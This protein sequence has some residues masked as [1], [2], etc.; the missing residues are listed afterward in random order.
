[1]SLFFSTVSIGPYILFFSEYQLQCNN[2]SLIPSNEDIYLIVN[3][4]Q[5]LYN[6]KIV[7][8]WSTFLACPLLITILWPTGIAIVSWYSSINGYISKQARSAARWAHLV[9]VKVKTAIL[10]SFP[11]YSSGHRERLLNRT[12]SSKLDRAT[13]MTWKKGKIQWRRRGNLP[14]LA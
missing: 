10:C 11:R 1:M 3:P 13:I 9:A 12:L 5:W 7:C 2:V 6:W 14:P 4:F 8:F